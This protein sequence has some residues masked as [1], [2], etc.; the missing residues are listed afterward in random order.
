MNMLRLLLVTILAASV[1]AAQSNSRTLATVDGQAITEAEVVQAAAQ[2]LATLDASRPQPQSAYERARLE[3][4]WRTLDSL[5]DERLITL[6]A[7]KQ[8][9]SRQE[10]IDAE[11]ESNVY[12][13]RHR[14]Q[15]RS[16]VPKSRRFPPSGSS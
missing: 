9:K 13:T 8:Q 12:T 1:A 5:I 15:R 10:L 11:I 3:I 7:A 16:P 14:S 6:E 2:D 4:L